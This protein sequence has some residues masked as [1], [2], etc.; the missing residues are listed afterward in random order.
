MQARQRA[1][2]NETGPA[3]KNRS[4]WKFKSSAAYLKKALN[5]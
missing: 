3:A 4:R 2:I 5:I 1:A